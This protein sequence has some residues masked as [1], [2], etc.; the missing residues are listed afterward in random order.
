MTEQEKILDRVRKLLELASSD[1][2]HESASATKQAQVLMSKHSIS[3]AMLDIGMDDDET[4]EAVEDDLLHRHSSRQMPS[5]KGRLGVVMCE[6][7]Q[8]KCYRRHGGALKIIGR[9][10]DAAT[11]RYL[12]SYVVREIDR[13]TNLEASYR[14]SPGRTWCNN[15][16]IGAVTEV[17]E[18]LRE[19]AKEA[20]ADMKRDADAGDSLGNGTALVRVNNAIAKLD[21]RKQ[22]ADNFGKRIGLRA[23]SGSRSR[24][25]GNARNAGRKA[26]ASINLNGSRGGSLGS[27]T[28]RALNG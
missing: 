1:N 8:C 28:R 24:F 9:P 13:L 11:V 6:V 26:G 10:S 18:R 23:R 20:R 17:N 7:N 21:D 4:A 19:A 5:W 25:D 27:G 22:A 3:Q 12:F 14:G 16:R 2:V 15:F